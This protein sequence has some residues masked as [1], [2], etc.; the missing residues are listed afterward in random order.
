MSTATA[1]VPLWNRAAE[2]ERRCAMIARAQT[3]LYVS[4][5][6]IEHDAYGIEFCAALRAAARR[7]VF[8]N[9]LIDAFGQRLGGLVMSRTQRRALAD[10][11][12]SMRRDGV[13]VSWYR[14]SHVVQRLVG[15]GQHVKIQISEEGEALFSSGNITRSSYEG[16]NEYA[17]AVSGPVT[18]ELL[19]SYAAIGGVVQPVHLNM[20]PASGGDLTIDYW[21]F[22]PNPYQ[23]ARG[24]FGWAGRN[25][26]TD[27]LVALID[28]ASTSVS[29]TS[30]YFKPTGVLMDAVVRAARRGVRV[31]VFHS[32][33]D[34]LPTTDL[35]W[36]AA[37]A[38][39]DRLLGAGVRI[40]EN[41]HGEHSKIV[42][43]DDRVVSFGSYNFEDAAHDRLAEAMLTSADSRAVQPARVIFDDLRRHTDNE[44][45]TLE[46]F[47]A[48]PARTK[49]R[50]ARYGRFKRWM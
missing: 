28:S 21:F 36:I 17:V 34:A 9:L 24:P 44:L 1:L 50:V 20:L 40:Y 25:T 8:V 35:A 46:T 49:A 6:Y 30:F 14:P 13:V 37:A 7:G 42:L 23:G 4:T 27:Q 11:L 29:I 48:L 10:E 2:W 41:R 3:F 47:A 33:R 38:G 12:E 15:A 39:Y 5:F 31:E 26:V 18:R 19:E 16:W 32:H 43:V 45:V 22:N